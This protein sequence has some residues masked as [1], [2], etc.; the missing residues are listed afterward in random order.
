MPFFGP[1]RI[2]AK[3]GSVRILA[4]TVEAQEFI[5]A[6]P[7]ERR[8]AMHWMRARKALDRGWMGSQAEYDAARAFRLA[9]QTDDLLID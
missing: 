6:L 4:T 8:E 1:F 5:K 9:L 7:A 2:L 3:S